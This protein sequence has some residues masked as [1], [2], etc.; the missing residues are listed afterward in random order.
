MPSIDRI[1]EDFDLIK[2]LGYEEDVYVLEEGR[3]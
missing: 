3:S 1:D 2:D